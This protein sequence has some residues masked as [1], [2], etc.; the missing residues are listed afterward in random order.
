[1][2]RTVVAR[3]I[4]ALDQTQTGDADPLEDTT[5]LPREDFR[6]I[7][8]PEDYGLVTRSSSSTG[9]RWLNHPPQSS[10]HTA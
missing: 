9:V 8:T 3:V 2:C 4:R 7:R 10:Q 1:M 5:D 6:G